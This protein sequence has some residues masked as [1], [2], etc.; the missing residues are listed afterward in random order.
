[1]TILMLHLFL[2]KKKFPKG[3]LGKNQFYKT[4]IKIS[5]TQLLT[6]V[7][8]NNYHDI[9]GDIIALGWASG[10]ENIRYLGSEIYALTKTG[11]LSQEDFVKIQEKMGSIKK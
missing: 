4:D 7:R 2:L 1:M 3:L 11:E 6:Q 10:N 5:Y 9:G 8:I